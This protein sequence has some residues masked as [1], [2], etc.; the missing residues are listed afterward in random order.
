LCSS[1][2]PRRLARLDRPVSANCRLLALHHTE[3]S[4]ELISVVTFI[5]EGTGG[6]ESPIL[7]QK[8][9]P[10]P[11]IGITPAPPR[12]S[13]LRSTIS[14]QLRGRPCPEGLREMKNDTSRVDP[15]PVHP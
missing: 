10:W 5:E 11:W 14:P 8:A 1:P 4:R 13:G 7:W 6:F 15:P 3:P 2:P 9:D 12:P